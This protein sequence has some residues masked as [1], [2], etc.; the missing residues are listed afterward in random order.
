MEMRY[1]AALA[2]TAI[3]VTAVGIYTVS[4]PDFSKETDTASLMPSEQ[5]MKYYTLAAD[6]ERTLPSVKSTDLEDGDVLKQHYRSYNIDTFTALEDS[7]YNESIKE[8]PDEIRIRIVVFKN[9]EIAR[10]ET[11]NFISSRPT[12][13][14]V[15]TLNLDEG[16]EAKKIKATVNKYENLFIISKTVGN[17][18]FYVSTKSAKKW[19]YFS[20]NKSV[21]ISKTIYKNAVN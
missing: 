15:S 19:E 2:I 16:V 3:A 20:D 17:L 12:N 1:N 21:S 11:E 6:R 4:T 7:V 13:S 5:E 14:T 8:L 18:H 9:R 10:T